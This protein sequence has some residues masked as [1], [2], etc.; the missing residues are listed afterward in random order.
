MNPPPVIRP[1]TEADLPAISQIYNE[2]IRTGVATWDEAPWTEDQRLHWWTHEH[3]AD[4]TCPVLVAETDGQVV[5]FAYLSKMS[6]KSG[7]RFTREDTIYIGDAWQGR[8]IGRILLT[9]IVHLAQDLGM[10][11]L[12]ATIESGNV[13]SLALHRELGFTVAGELRNAGFKFERWLDVTY[14]QRDLA[15]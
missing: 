10:R 2:A 11:L 8:G 15:E 13:R 7:W 14:M 3:A 9:A 1:A 4:P 6:Q 12:V 5:G